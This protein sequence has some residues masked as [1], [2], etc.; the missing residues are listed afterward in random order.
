[1]IV[2]GEPFLIEYNVRMGDP[3]CQTIL[4]RL[5]TDF[6]DIVV[7]TVNEDLKNINL[8][9]FGEKS[10]CVVLA[11][12]GYPDE[13]KNNSEIK[14]LKEIK[15]QDNEYIFHAGTKVNNSKIY[16]NGGRVLNFVIKSDNLKIGRDKA[17]SLINK[18]NWQNGYFRKD[19]GFKIIS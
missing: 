13:F 1:M 11:S 19:I 9:W 10:I 5:K 17:I 15:L 7:A 3:E 14:G 2:K 12:K 4:P 16:S 6:L 18:L 8:E